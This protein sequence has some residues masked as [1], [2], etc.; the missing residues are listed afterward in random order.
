MQTCLLVIWMGIQP[1]IWHLNPE[2][3]G[4]GF[5]QSR[6]LVSNFHAQLDLHKRPRDMLALRLVRINSWIV[7]VADW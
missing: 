4:R 5:V 3:G 6:V 1:K 7:V 2:G